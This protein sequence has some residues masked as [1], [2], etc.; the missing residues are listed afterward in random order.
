MIRVMVENFLLFLL[1]T[2]LY[3]AFRYVQRARSRDEAV[4]SGGTTVRDDINNAPFL[5]LFLAGAL[6]VLATLIA[7]GSA[8]DSGKPGQTYY[9]PTIK[10]GKKIPGHFK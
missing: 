2:V 7:F 6:L 10:D 4:A 9:P 8:S 5:W 3:L 1:P